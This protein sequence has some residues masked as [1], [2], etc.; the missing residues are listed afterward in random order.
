M[1]AN[2]C[3]ISLILIDPIQ[4]YDHDLPIMYYNVNYLHRASSLLR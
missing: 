4:S 3:Q 2:F 1:Y